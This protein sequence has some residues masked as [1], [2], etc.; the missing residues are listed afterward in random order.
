MD[1]L[2]EVFHKT[3]IENKGLKAGLLSHAAPLSRTRASRELLTKSTKNS[4]YESPDCAI[5]ACIIVINWF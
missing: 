5:G 2:H 4:C 1:K 3:G